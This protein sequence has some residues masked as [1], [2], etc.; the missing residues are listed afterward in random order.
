MRT[1]PPSRSPSP[2]DGPG[3]G[4]W[5]HI[6]D[7]FPGEGVVSSSSN[8]LRRAADAVVTVRVGDR[9]DLRSVPAAEAVLERTKSR[10]EENPRPGVEGF[11]PCFGFP[12]QP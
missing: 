6:Y 3:S 10:C 11:Y 12:G 2:S 8:D 9:V 7:R 5:T 1:T 4:R